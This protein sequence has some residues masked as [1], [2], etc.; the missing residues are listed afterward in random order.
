MSFHRSKRTRLIDDHAWRAQVISDQPLHFF[1][2]RGCAEGLNLYDTTPGVRHLSDIDTN[3]ARGNCRER[4]LTPDFVVAGH[5][6]ARDRYPTASVP[7][8]H[9]EGLQTVEAEG[10]RLS[11]TV[12]LCVVVVQTEDADLV[13]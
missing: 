5:T 10:L 7:V 13:N 6:A 9:V 8:L 2:A 11:R 3:L 12:F 4:K 1:T